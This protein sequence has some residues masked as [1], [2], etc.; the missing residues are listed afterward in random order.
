MYIPLMSSEQPK[1]VLLQ[2]LTSQKNKKNYLIKPS[3][4]ISFSQNTFAAAK[5]KYCFVPKMEKKESD[6][7]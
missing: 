2:I 6:N 1:N 4:S 3:L 7:C 5:Y